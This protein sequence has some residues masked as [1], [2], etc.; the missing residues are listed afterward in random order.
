MLITNIARNRT[1]DRSAQIIPPSP[2]RTAVMNL[3]NLEY[4]W[5]TEL[6]NTN[7]QFRENREYIHFTIN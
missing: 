2:S 7:N 3:M 4:N 1:I 6:M 5:K